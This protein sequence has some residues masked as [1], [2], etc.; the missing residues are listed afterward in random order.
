MELTLQPTITPLGP[1]L[2]AEVRG[3][4]LARPL[5]EDTVRALRA[6][7]LEHLVL[8]FRGQTLTGPQLRVFSERFGEPELAPGSPKDGA[9]ADGGRDPYIGVVSNVV[10]NGRPLGAL[11]SGELAWHT[12]MSFLA[13]PPTASILYAD[14]IPPAGGDTYF[15][16][17]VKALDTMPPDLRA[18]LD[19]LVLTHDGTTNSANEPRRGKTQ[20]HDVL[21]AE[22]WRHP[23]V[24]V[25]PETRRVALY[26]GRRLNAYAVGRTVA[27][28]E[29]LLDRIWGALTDPA[30]QARLVYRHRW[31]QG[32][33][34]MWDNRCTM[35]RATDYDASEERR[36]IHRTVVKGDI[37]V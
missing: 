33:V 13:T 14:T 21:R 31:R 16:N 34:L 8:L 32:D 5:S 19:T 29:A 6:A 2:G 35:H 7:W 24:R 10:E 15:M 11:G 12:D 9:A 18:A 4:D 1:A 22:G 17:M 25:H 36:V 3:I 26:L 28:S 20:T 30:N 27:D 23:A 37:P